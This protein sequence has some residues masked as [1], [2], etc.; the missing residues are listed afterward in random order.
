MDRTTQLN[1]WWEGLGDEGRQAARRRGRLTPEQRA[2]L[3]RAGLIDKHKPDDE[4]DDEDVTFL[5][6][7]RH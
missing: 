4:D 6:K 3:K 1:Q 5:L 2:S 7:M